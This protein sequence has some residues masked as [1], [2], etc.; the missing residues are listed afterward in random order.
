[1]REAGDSIAR[2]SLRPFVFD[3]PINAAS[4]TEWIEEQLCPTLAAA[5]IVIIDNKLSHKKP[6]V[7]AAL[8]AR[9]ARL[10]FLPRT[11]D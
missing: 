5:D 9:G 2:N 8:R 10:S 7:R 3:Q 1:M 6:V 11:F 4:L